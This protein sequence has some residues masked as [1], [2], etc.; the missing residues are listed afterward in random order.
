[1]VMAAMIEHPHER[2][3]LNTYADHLE[4]E[5]RQRVLAGWAEIAR[6]RRV[7]EEEQLRAAR[8]SMWGPYGEDQNNG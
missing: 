6:E 2:A 3:R 7:R 1:M 8:I 5:A 4:A